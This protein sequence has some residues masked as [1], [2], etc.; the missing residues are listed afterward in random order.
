MTENQAK[1]L[2][3][4]IRIKCQ[5]ILNSVLDFGTAYER[6]LKFVAED[7]LKEIKESENE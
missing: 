5:L 4:I 2:I 3:E 6:G 1:N 7:I